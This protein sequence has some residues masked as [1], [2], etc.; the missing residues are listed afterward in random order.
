MVFKITNASNF[1]LIFLI[2]LFLFFNFFIFF[3]FGYLGK[4]CVSIVYCLYKYAVDFFPIVFALKGL[5]L[6]G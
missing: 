6:I 2:F 4:G 5:G 1:P 3:L